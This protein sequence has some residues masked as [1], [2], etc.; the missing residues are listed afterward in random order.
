MR[1]AIRRTLLVT[2]LRLHRSWR[3]LRDR[4]RLLLFQATLLVGGWV[5]IVL[6]GSQVPGLEASGE[7]AGDIDPTQVREMTRGMV[8]ALWLF[9]AGLAASGT[10]T[11]ASSVAG[12]SF[13]LRSADIRPTLWGTVLA[14]YARR[15]ALFGLFAVGTAV[16]L[17]WGLGLPTRSPL[18]LLA[19]MLLFF[20]AE[21][22][23]MAARLALAATGYSPSSAGRV[24]AGGVALVVFSFALGYPAASLSV[25]S[26]VPVA[27][28]AEAFLVRVPGVS[29]DRAALR[30][31]VLASLVALPLLGLLTERL[32]RRTW[33]RGRQRDA[34]GTDRTRVGS[35]LGSLGVEGPARAV[36]WR[37]WLQTRR[38]PITA[39]L[40]GVPL[41]VVGLGV[42]DPQG[43]DLPLFP[44]TMG[45]YA[46]W[47]TGFVLALNP[48]SS[49]DGTLPHLLTAEGDEIVTGYTLIA[50]AVGLPVTVATVV[51]AGLLIGPV[52]LLP[53]ALVVSVAVFLGTVPAGLA[54]GLLLPRMEAVPF[55]SDGPITPSKF[56]MAGHTVV[57][58]TLAAPTALGVLAADELGVAPLAVVGIVATILASL[59]VGLVGQQIAANR[60][61][62][63]TVK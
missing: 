52:E 27:N 34:P 30:L 58:A 19:L 59:G 25:L 11:H 63:L 61:D 35:W 7:G 50:A 44:L 4:P 17:L 43:V 62:Q 14:E 42:V 39:G 10:P 56:A 24:V 2:R 26:R 33:F 5:Y 45:L 48:L 12:G 16:T 20:T 9:L 51:A 49:E 28:F 36:A 8:A 38:Q 40:V 15:L 22:A 37:V 57:I 53:A 13:L 55:D 21:L 60:F 6:V 47:M 46:V 18:V 1:Q 29:P 31:T 54:M 41:L 23:G 32:A 3:R